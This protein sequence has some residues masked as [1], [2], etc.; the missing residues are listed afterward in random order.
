MW[1]VV[2]GVVSGVVRDV[3]V[4][5]ETLETL[6]V[7][8]RCVVMGVIRSVVRS[9]VRVMFRGVVR[10]SVMD[11]VLWAWSWCGVRVVFSE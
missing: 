9:V 4:W 6:G 7:W 5:L 2:S 10:R 3:I 11:V 1:L 8:L